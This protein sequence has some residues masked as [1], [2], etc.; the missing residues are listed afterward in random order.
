MSRIELVMIVRDEAR[1]LARCLASARAFVD[2]IVVV[3]TGSVD[4][5][6]E[7]ARRHGAR[8]ER[9]AWCDDFAAA[10]NAA[11]AASDAPWR[12]VLDADEWIAEGGASL[13]ALRGEPA[14]F[15]GQ[16]RVASAFDSGAGRVEEA[17]S[18]LPRSC[19][20]A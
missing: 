1:C 17:P 15:I 11:L 19:R 6:I 7:I 10:R 18:W 9:F 14:A 12:L 13:A 2:G 20:A 4:A 16:I 8:V 3:D 5:T